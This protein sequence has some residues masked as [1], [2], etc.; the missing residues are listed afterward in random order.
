LLKRLLERLLEHFA[1]LL[2]LSLQL[3][4]E[5]LH[6]MQVNF[7]CDLLVLAFD[8]QRGLLHILCA[9]HVLVGSV[10]FERDKLVQLL[11]VQEENLILCK[12]KVFCSNFSVLETGLDLSTSD[13]V[14]EIQIVILI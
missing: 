5:V 6:A 12:T 13:E 9:L 10:L 4:F 2:E 11:I 3:L 8:C 14:L 1:L 7:S